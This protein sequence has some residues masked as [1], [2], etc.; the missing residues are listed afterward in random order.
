MTDRLTTAVAAEPPEL[1]AGPVAAQVIP[2]RGGAGQPLLVRKFVTG[3][4]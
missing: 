2:E 4:S 3:L 1:V